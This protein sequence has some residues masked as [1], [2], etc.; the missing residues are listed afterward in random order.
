MDYCK[1][2]GDAV[3][4]VCEKLLGFDVEA[5]R[6]MVRRGVRMIQ[7]KEAHAEHIK[8]NDTPI[9]KSYSL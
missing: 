4:D 1:N 2:G 7:C 3:L 5:R 8:D 6:V 9:S